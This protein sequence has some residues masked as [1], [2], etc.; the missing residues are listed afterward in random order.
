MRRHTALITVFL[1]TLVLCSAL[2]SFAQRRDYMTEAEIELVRDNQDIDKRMDVLTK[3]IDRRFT[4]LG[5]DVGGWKQ[6]Q[7]DEGLWGELPAASRSALLSDVRQLLQKA[8][9]DI[10]DVSEHN[11]KTLTQNKTEGLLFPA[12]VRALAS[13]AARYVP[14]LQSALEKTTDER[15]KGVI[16]T[17]IESCR[18]ILDSVSSLPAETKPVKKK[19]KS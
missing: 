14:A 11:E 15:D 18:E 6:S 4:A 5:I 10:D 2:P 9:D 3:M 1:A 7:K 16:L 17:S 19:G 12:A 8:I 13:A